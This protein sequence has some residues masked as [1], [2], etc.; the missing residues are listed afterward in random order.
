MEPLIRVL[1]A[2]DHAHIRAGVRL[3]LE[4][5]GFEVVGEA[6]T[7]EQAVVL[8]R[9]TRPDVCLVDV[10]MPG[11]GGAEAVAQILA[12]MPE[13]ACVMLT[14][15][16]DDVDLFASLRAGA[17][18]YLLKDIDPDGLAPA[19]RGVLKGEAAV[20][21]LLV[22]R[23]IDELRAKNIRRVA[24]P[25]RRAVDLT[26]REAAVLQGLRDGKST[27]E[28]AASLGVASVT[29]RNYIHTLLKKLRVP[30]RESAVALFEH[31]Q[32]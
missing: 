17:V 5:E 1:L 2:D 3:S 30:D 24:L 21:R 16:Q 29:V 25:G 6:A 10:H 4:Q 23:L 15:S 8:A 7:G 32:D 13:T 14:A 12:D 22:A 31:H 9:E 28:I 20:P 11:G 18:G 27:K 19:L 26:E